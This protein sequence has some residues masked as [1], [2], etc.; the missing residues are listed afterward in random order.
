M[1]ERLGYR[2]AAIMAR[3]GTELLLLAAL[4][5]AVLNRLRRKGGARKPPD[6]F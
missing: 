4:P 2:L 1:N 3:V 5:V 6:R